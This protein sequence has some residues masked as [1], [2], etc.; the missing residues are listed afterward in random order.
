MNKRKLG[1]SS[2]EVGPLAFG[3]NVMGWT[4]DAATSYAML[5]YFVARGLN[6]VDTA[7]VYSRWAPGHK[8]GESE[9]IIGEWIAKRKANRE[10][11]VLA[12]KVGIEMGPSDKGLSRAYIM[13]AVDASL[14][15][16]QTDYIDL[17]QSHQDD[18][19]VPQEE[20]LSAY[21]D[22]IRAGKV[23]IIGASN[24]TP[25][26]LSEA[27]A[28]SKRNGLPRYE[29][30][31]PWYNLYDRKDF[32]GAPFDLCKREN[33]SVITYFSLAS[34]F[35]TGK[36]RKPKDAEGKARGYRVKDMLNERGMRIL[37]ALDAVGKELE[38]TP[39]QVSLAWL[40]AKGVTAPIAS[41]TTVAQLEEIVESTELNLT[42]DQIKRLD[43]ASAY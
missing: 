26:R 42:A 16:L 14:K 19:S 30:L 35:L 28:I 43:Q 40:V 6:L 38:A 18:A 7:D 1:N 27:L 34:G 23:R 24:F 11:I 33:I 3:T 9:T 22:L 2:I 36:Y 17:Y 13:R 41:A 15:R 10:K 37:A 32:E 5:D 4:A 8:G 29:T 31:Q 39:A 20:T 25:E 21:A 12:T